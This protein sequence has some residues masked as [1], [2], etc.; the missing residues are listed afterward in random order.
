MLE[1]HLQ[2]NSFYIS[3]LHY[4]RTMLWFTTPRGKP[5]TVHLYRHLSTST[6]LTITHVNPGK[7]CIA[8]AIWQLRST[9]LFALIFIYVAKKKTITFKMHIYQFMK[10]S[11][12]SDCEI[13]SFLS[14]LH[15]LKF[16][17]IST[18][19]HHVQ[20][21]LRTDQQKAACCDS[22]VRGWFIPIIDNGPFCL[23]NFTKK[24]SLKWLCLDINLIW[25]K[26]L[27]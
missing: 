2:D 21:G 8:H 25:E 19:L 18:H 3:G 16:L 20:V 12:N 23:R 6:Y 17:K 14:N 10:F 15:N 13:Q 9:Q 27:S 11:F 26:Q 7:Y 1:F 5:N 24:I 4:R 22:C